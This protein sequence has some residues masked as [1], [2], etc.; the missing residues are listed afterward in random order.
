MKKKN[1]LIILT[2]NKRLPNFNDDQSIDFEDENSENII[3]T[4]DNK[5]IGVISCEENNLINE[6]NKHEYIKL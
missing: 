6:M 1:K 2:N 3:F 4:N 5:K